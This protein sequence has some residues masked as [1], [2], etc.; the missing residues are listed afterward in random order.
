MPIPRPTVDI[1]HPPPGF[2][3]VVDWFEQVSYGLVLLEEY[4]LPDVRAATESLKGAVRTHIRGTRLPTP[5][6][7]SPVTPIAQERVLL[8][9]DHIWFGTSLDQL[10]WFYRIV[11]REDHGGH[12]QALGQ[13]GRVLAE[14]LRRHRTHERAYLDAVAASRPVGNRQ[15]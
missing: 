2:D 10:D 15:R 5:F 12:R 8:E 4:P 1:A 14:S 7:A 6:R 3:D 9:S 13:Y 11:E